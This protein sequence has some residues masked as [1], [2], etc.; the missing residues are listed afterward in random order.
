MSERARL[1]WPSTATWA[2]LVECMHHCFL[3][4]LLASL[5]LLIAAS[6]RLRKGNRT[7]HAFEQASHVDVTSAS[8]RWVLT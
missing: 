7:D 4:S 1:Q 5:S 6:C 2:R 8:S 3:L